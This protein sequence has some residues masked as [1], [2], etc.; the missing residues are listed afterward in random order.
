MRSKHQK[1]AQNG[2]G[3]RFVDILGHNVHFVAASQ[4]GGFKPQ[5]RGSR[6]AAEQTV[7]NGL[8]LNNRHLHDGFGVPVVALHQRFG[9]P[10]EPCCPV[11]EPDG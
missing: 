7:G 11:S 6:R 5:R 3:I 4:K 10:H 2:I 1:G 9:G 8:Q